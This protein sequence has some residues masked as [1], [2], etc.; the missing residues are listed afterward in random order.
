MRSSTFMNALAPRSLS[1]AVL[2][3]FHPTDIR[4]GEGE[5]EGRRKTGM[6]KKGF[7]S[8]MGMEQQANDARQQLIYKQ[9]NDL[10]TLDNILMSK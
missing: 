9:A 1:F 4:R 3:G 7:L 2:Q 5:G 10:V 8:R 6:R